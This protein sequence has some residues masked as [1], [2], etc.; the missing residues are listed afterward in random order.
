MT[1]VFVSHASRDKPRIGHIVDDLIAA[2]YRLFIDHPEGIGPRFTPDFCAANRI[3]TLWSAAGETNWSARL[4]RALRECDCVLVIASDALTLPGLAE[5]DG[6]RLAAED[7]HHRIEWKAEIMWGHALQKLVFAK[8]GSFDSAV[9]PSYVRLMDAIDVSATLDPAKLANNLAI[10]RSSRI[11]PAVA[12]AIRGP[13]VE[14]FRGLLDLLPL[15][16]GRREQRRVIAHARRR[17]AENGSTP[18]IVLATPDNELPPR[19]FEALPLADDGSGM[20]EP[21]N[22]RHVELP[23]SR[24]DAFQQDFA[25]SLIEEFLHDSY[26]VH[27]GAVADHLRGGTPT[28]VV[29]IVTVRSPLTSLPLAD[30]I[31]FWTRFAADFPRTP[32]I[33]VLTVLLGQA[34]PGW[35]DYPPRQKLDRSSYKRNKALCEWLTKEAAG[36]AQPPVFAFPSLLR[37]IA[38]DQALGWTRD[39][40]PNVLASNERDRLEAAVTSTIYPTRAERDDGVNHAVFADRVRAF[41]EMLGRAA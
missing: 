15:C 30:W 31:A 41:F 26:D 18:P 36:A 38:L 2:G 14:Q 10:L 6:W 28:I 11:A 35:P 34:A 5:E 27:L 24:G 25:F 13:R 8:I 22:V 7:T 9:L 12:A 20:A 32:A 16:V 4:E 40:R 39:I 37:P 19:F 29:S 23:S 33:P 17:L 1:Y 21:V 3:E